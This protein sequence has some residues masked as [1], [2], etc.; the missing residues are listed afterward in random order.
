MR[1]QRIDN[2]KCIV[3]GPDHYN[4]LGLIR[5]L[6]EA[7]IYPIVILWS[8]TPVLA[9]HSKY[10][11][12]LHIVK[13]IEDGYTLLMTKYG[14]ETEKP[15]LY[16]TMDK[17]VSFIDK[18]YNEIKDK[19]YTYNS[20]GEQGRLNWLMNKDNI[21]NLGIQAGL[22]V[23][24]KEV[25]KTGVLPT[26]IKYPIITKVLISTMGAWKGDVHICYNQKELSEAYKSIKAPQLIIQ[27]YIKKKGEFCFEG[28]SINDGKDILL[29]YI[30]NYIRYYED[31]YGH[32]MAVSAVEEN[33]LIQKIRELFKLS[34]YNG[35]FEIEFMKGPEEEKYFLEIN[36]RT[37]PWLYATTVGGVNLPY[38][39]AK[40]TL[41]GKIPY[42]NVNIRKSYFTA[43]AEPSDFKMNAKKIG[44]FTWMK[45]CA[46]STC[47][48]YY[49]KKDPKPFF[50]YLL[51][52]LT[53]K[54]VE[55]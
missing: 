21:T 14:H 22:D 11:S 2:H 49:N 19:F 33:E 53:R 13:T 39:W 24:K 32:Y 54:H 8:S 40:S 45:Q 37:S 10:I 15:F 46:K 18:H 1:N 6:G 16:L 51:S 23:P 17:I 25:V 38:L 35:I 20:G 55:E 31:S 36:F 27:E 26:K 47:H 44:Y 5:S 50:F 34:K 28:F 4:P 7:G 9:N 42:E 30:F 12:E 43:M 52:K 41:L 48:Y 3:F 29:P